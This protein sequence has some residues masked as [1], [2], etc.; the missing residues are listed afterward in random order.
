MFTDI[1]FTFGLT[2]TINFNS[3][4]N[5]PVYGYYFQHR[6]VNELK[7]LEGLT[8][9]SKLILHSY[10]NNTLILL[11]LFNSYIFICDY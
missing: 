10:K 8:E 5:I 4:Y 11:C 2:E 3:V 6:T 7:K 1:L 9:P